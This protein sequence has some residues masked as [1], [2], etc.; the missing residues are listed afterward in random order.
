MYADS[1]Q[2]ASTR[3]LRL[4]T[5][6]NEQ[7]HKDKDQTGHKDF[8]NRIYKTNNQVPFKFVE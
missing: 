4:H 2:T 8:I 3:Q 5:D 1:S 7:I 6:F